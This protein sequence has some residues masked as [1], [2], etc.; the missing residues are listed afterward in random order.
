M[1][2]SATLLITQID[3]TLINTIVFI[4]RRQHERY[5]T[6]AK[7]SLIFTANRV[8]RLYSTKESPTNHVPRGKNVYPY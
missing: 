7:H 5:D 8:G 2:C 1:L 3:T 4:G 6:S